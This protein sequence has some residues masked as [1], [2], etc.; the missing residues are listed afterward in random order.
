MHTERDR[1]ALKCIE[2]VTVCG[3]ETER[4]LHQPGRMYFKP[5]THLNSNI[6]VIIRL[7]Y[8]AALSVLHAIIFL[9][10]HMP[11]ARVRERPEHIT[12]R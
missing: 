5:S 1:S 10:E 6:P 12:L 8:C 2:K 7:Y 4:E 3:L 11:E 9:S